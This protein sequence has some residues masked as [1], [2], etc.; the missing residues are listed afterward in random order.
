[1]AV[2][3]SHGFLSPNN[4]QLE[5]RPSTETALQDLYRTFCS[6]CLLS[7]TVV[8]S[9]VTEGWTEQLEVTL[10]TTASTLEV[11]WLSSLLLLLYYSIPNREWK[12]SVTIFWQFNLLQSIFHQV[13]RKSCCVEKCIK[14]NSEVDNIFKNYP[15]FWPT[16]HGLFLSNLCATVNLRE[17]S[18]PLC[19]FQKK[20]GKKDASTCKEILEF[21]IAFYAVA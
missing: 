2:A 8:T 19:S 21:P 1:M 11:T 9:S 3:Y 10:E 5:K 6:L 15:F 18:G 14:E 16:S 7:A 12:Y 13:Q 17:V 4:H 20:P